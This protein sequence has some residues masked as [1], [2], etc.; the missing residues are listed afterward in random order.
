VGA[1]IFQAGVLV[2]FIPSSGVGRSAGAAPFF[3]LGFFFFAS[4]GAGWWR[5]VGG[6]TMPAT[7]S[8]VG[9]CAA[10]GR[11]RCAGWLEKAAV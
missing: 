2:I 8:Y 3:F 5:E 11:W 1:L 4:A 6:A 10:I 9:G 7:S